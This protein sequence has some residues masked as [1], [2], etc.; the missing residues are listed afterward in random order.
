VSPTPVKVKYLI[1]TPSVPGPELPL[2]GSRTL[3]EKI[4]ARTTKAGYPSEVREVL[5]AG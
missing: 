2:V 4:A 3:A 1:L 5:L